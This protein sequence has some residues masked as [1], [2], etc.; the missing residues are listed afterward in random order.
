MK[1][2]SGIFVVLLLTLAGLWGLG[3]VK[4]AHDPGDGGYWSIE[5]PEI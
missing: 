2:F 3:E 5:N 4:T 1:R